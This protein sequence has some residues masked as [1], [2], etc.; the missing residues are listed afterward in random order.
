MSLSSVNKVLKKMHE[1]QSTEK[2]SFGEKAVFEICEEF[3]DNEGGILIHS[4]SYK[5]DPQ[6]AGNI[7]KNDNGQLF[8]EHLGD[9]TEIDIMYVSKYRIYPIEVKAY[10]ARSIQFQDDGIY[11]CRKTDKSPI[12]QNEMHC[13]H[14][15]SSIFR[16]LPNGDTSYIIPVVC[17][18]DKCDIT[19][20][21]SDWQKEYIHLCTLN[22][23]R[24]FILDT[25]TPL[26]CKLNLTLV[27]NILREQMIKNEVYLPVRL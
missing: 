1:H 4:Y 7:K 20:A 2:G 26:E 14:L 17:M 15:Y 19:D 8:I 25:N 3:Y 27:D 18:V 23:L 13:R 11:G 12:H 16:A 6:Q 22:T 10:R 21:R 5:T 9:F 24:S